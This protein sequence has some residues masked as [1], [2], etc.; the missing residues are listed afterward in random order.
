MDTYA[1]INDMQEIS[2]TLATYSVTFTQG[3]GNLREWDTMLTMCRQRYQ[4]SG[5]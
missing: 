4:L 5:S 1:T 3:F 2:H